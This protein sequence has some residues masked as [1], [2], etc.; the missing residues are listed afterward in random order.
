MRRFGTHPRRRSSPILRPPWGLRDPPF[1]WPEVCR[2]P[3]QRPLWFSRQSHC[4]HASPLRCHSSLRA[5]RR[6]AHGVPVRSIAARSASAGPNRVAPP[7]VL[8]T[9]PPLPPGSLF[10]IQDRVRQIWPCGGTLRRQR[11][12]RFGRLAALASKPQII[13]GFTRR[14]RGR[15]GCANGLVS[16]GLKWVADAARAGFGPCPKSCPWRHWYSSCKHPARLQ[17]RGRLRS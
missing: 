16:Q 1:R 7:G 3:R 4:V 2:P 17:G 14:A 5:S 11:T 6:Y 15:L 8:H 13:R 10:L 9:V 12:S